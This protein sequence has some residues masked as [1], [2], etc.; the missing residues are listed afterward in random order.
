MKSTVAWNVLF[1]GAQKDGRTGAYS[2]IEQG[3]GDL[4]RPPRG[5][6]PA[7][8]GVP[9]LR[10]RREQRGAACRQDERNH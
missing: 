1:H 10:E 7:A 5:A 4:G 8:G 3:R 2:T 9:R 6:G